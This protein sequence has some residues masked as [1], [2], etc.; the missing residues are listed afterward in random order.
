VNKLH[1]TLPTHGFWQW[2]LRDFRAA[3]IRLPA[4]LISGVIAPEGGDDKALL[5]AVNGAGDAREWV[6]EAER[7]R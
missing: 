1:G 4:T 2:R 7:M 5:E 6:T 3:Y